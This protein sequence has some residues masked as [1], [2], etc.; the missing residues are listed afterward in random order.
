MK[1]IVFIK[2]INNLNNPRDLKVIAI[3]SRKNILISESSYDTTKVF[4][5]Y[6]LV[7]EV[8]RTQMLI[9][10]SVYLA[11]SILE[12]SKM[13]LYDFRYDQVLPKH[14]EKA[15]LYYIDTGIFI[16][17]IKAE[18]ISVD[19]EKDVETRFDT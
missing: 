19:I 18:D 1:N 11:L 16:V 5:E 3:E 12:R 13:I 9:N 10:K 17:Y 8:K 14:G 4:S 6:L 15:K 7:I 2:T